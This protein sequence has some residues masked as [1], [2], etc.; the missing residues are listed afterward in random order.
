MNQAPCLSTARKA[1]FL[2]SWKPSSLMWGYIQWEEECVSHQFRIL[3]PARQSD[4]VASVQNTASTM[5]QKSESVH[6]ICAGRRPISFSKD[7]QEMWAQA[8][9]GDIWISYKAIQ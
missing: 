2:G 7:Q 5:V 4:I 3:L 6:F 8:N 1:P 9:A